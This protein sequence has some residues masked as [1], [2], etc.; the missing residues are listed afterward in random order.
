MKLVLPPGAPDAGA[1]SEYGDDIY[2]PLSWKMESQSADG[3]NTMILATGY[4]TFY[5]NIFR[6]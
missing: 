5:R 3:G 4:A 1:G 2:C 6:S